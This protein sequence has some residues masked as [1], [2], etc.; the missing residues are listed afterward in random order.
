MIILKHLTVERFRLLR[1]VNLHFPQRGSIFIQGPNE[2]GKSALL[3]SVYFALYGIPLSSE[4]GKRSLDD[5]I[6]YGATQ[7]TVTLTLSISTTELTITRT[8]ERG[9]GQKISL[10]VDKPGMPEERPITRLATANERILAELGRMDG[11]TLRNSCLLEQKGLERLETLFGSERE[12]TVRKL[13]GLEKLIRMTEHFKVTV[14]D[15]R[16]LHEAN[17]RFRLA[18]IQSHIPELSQQLEHLEDA[19]DAV[20]VAENLEEIQQQEAEIAEQKKELEQVASRRLELKNRQGRVQQL[21]KAEATLSEIIEAYDAIAEA[22]RKL[23]AL[24][25]EITDLERREREELPVQEKRVQELV[26]L[27]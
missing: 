4:R 3:E 26:E 27:T 18:E 14:H 1:E 15:D 9:K 21:K 11:E 13:L 25:K 2:S 8:I 12:A 22:R 20:A 19:L 7:A 10:S 23:P 24:E 6:M 5:L 16:Q 17:E